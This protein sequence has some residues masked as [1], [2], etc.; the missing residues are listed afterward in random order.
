MTDLAVQLSEE[1]VHERLA[2]LVA[3]DGS[4]RQAKKRLAL[5]GVDVEERELREVRME[6]AGLYQAMAVETAGAQEEAI[7]QNYRELT[8]GAQRVTVAFVQDLADKIDEKGMDGLPDDLR[9]QLPQTV[10]ALAKLMQTSTDKL[11]AVTGRPQDGGGGD[12][13]K[14]ADLLRSLGVLKTIERPTIDLPPEAVV[15]VDP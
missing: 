7:A 4:L 2:A 9:R 15:E 3:C 8:L 11:L 12:V 10:Q 14:A 13:E 1:Q 5:A 6:H